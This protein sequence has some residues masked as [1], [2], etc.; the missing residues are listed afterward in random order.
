MRA[1]NIDRLLL[2]G[3]QECNPD[4][5]KAQDVATF[6]ATV[7]DQGQWLVTLASFW[8]VRTMAELQE[9]LRSTIE[10]AQPMEL[11]SVHMCLFTARCPDVQQ[12]TGAQ[13]QRAF[14]S[15]QLRC[16]DA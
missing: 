3:P 11:L 8:G 4:F 10:Y 7:P 15:Q 14:D 12:P 2:V 13:V 5:S 6:A 1:R 16:P 9:K